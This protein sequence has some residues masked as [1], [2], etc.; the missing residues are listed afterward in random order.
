MKTIKVLL[1]DDHA[2]VRAGLR[3]LLESAED[4]QVIGE[5][6]NGQQALEAAKRLRPEVVLL[7]VAMPRMNGVEAARRITRTV[8]T[9]RVLM[10]SSYSDEQH[11][12]QAVAAGVAGYL[13]KESAANELLAAVRETCAG[14]ACFSPPLF[15]RLVKDS[16]GAPPDGPS[17]TTKPATL[18]RRQS[19]HLQLIAEGYCSKQ[20]AELLSVTLKTVEKHRQALMDRLNLHNIAKLTR[21][22]VS[23]GVIE[24]RHGLHPPA[25]PVLADQP[26]SKNTPE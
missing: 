7:D 9:A 1:V 22:A 19:D 4:M 12:K 18:S 17:A 16:W 8:P 15:N 25:T 10:L 21:Y 20:I 24:S 3:A 2:V 14:G 5:A 11:L 23:T 26:V 6:E 13:M